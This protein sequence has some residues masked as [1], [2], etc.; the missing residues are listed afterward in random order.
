M[1]EVLTKKGIDSLTKSVHLDTDNKCAHLD[2]C[3]TDCKGMFHKYCDKL[4]WAVDRAKMYAKIIP[5]ATWED[6][7]AAWE[8][9][10]SYWYMN[11]YQ[12]GGQPDI[13]STS[14]DIVMYN[15]WVAD[16]KEKWG[17]DPKNWKFVCAKCGN[18][19]CSQ[20]FIDIGEDPEGK[21][22]FSCIGRYTKK[23]GC[24]WTLGGL[25]TIHKT[26]VVKDMLIIPVFET[27]DPKNVNK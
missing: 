14:R 25:F 2:G 21:V 16:L 18:I 24:D 15:D 27:A 12:D 23:V 8:K 9:S 13:G 19:Q 5:D 17:K 26:V 10:R 3:A 6:I 1:S 20:D 11:Y 7:L 22:Y 4:K